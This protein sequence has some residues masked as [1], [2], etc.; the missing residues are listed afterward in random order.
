M[1][2]KITNLIFLGLAL[3]LIPANKAKA[4]DLNDP[5]LIG[6]WSFDEGAG[7]VANDLSKNNYDGT[8]IIK[9]F[10]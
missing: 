8:N 6:Y 1:C 4:F 5:D 10:Y 7:T 9:L 3:A 2:G